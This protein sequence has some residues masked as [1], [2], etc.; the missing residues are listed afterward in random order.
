MAG[1]PRSG[2]HGHGDLR[3][4]PVAHLGLDFGDPWHRDRRHHRIVI[5]VVRLALHPDLEGRVLPKRRRLLAAPM[6]MDVHPAMG[7][8]VVR[9]G[10]G[11]RD[12]EGR[13]PFL[14][15]ERFQPNP[16]VV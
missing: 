13:L 15:L 8:A 4:P 11:G 6:S 10:A 2:V 1:S 12:P 9:L 5:V 14:G 3:P 7:L 16:A